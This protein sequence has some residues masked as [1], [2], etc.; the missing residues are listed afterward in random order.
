MLPTLEV[1]NIETTQK[2][3]SNEENDAK[4]RFMELSLNNDT[5][6]ELQQKDPFCANIL[7][8]IEK[9]NIIEGQFYIVQNK[10]LRSDT[11]FFLFNSKSSM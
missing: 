7:A 5:L 3:L 1:S 10:L 9:E 11:S 6:F 4:D 2:V 8:Q